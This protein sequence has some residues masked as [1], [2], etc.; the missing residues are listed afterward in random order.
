MDKQLEVQKI[1]LSA[2]DL[3]ETLFGKILL[4]TQEFDS[5]VVTLTEAHLGARS[6]HSR[7]GN[8]LANALIELAKMRAIRE[9]Q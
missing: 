6:P 5:E 2:S 7:A 1:T 8:N 4:D 3:I 9:E